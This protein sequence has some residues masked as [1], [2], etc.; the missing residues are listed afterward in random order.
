MCCLSPFVCCHPSGVRWASCR[1][2]ATCQ[3][4]QGHLLHVQ[5]TEELPPH[6]LSEL[7]VTYLC[8]PQLLWFNASQ[9]CRRSGFAWCRQ[10]LSAGMPGRG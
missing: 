8:L 1:R 3:H 2:A 5:L 7:L 4:A 10:L 9:C 6:W